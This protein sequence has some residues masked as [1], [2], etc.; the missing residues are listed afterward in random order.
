[1]KKVLYIT[2][3]SNQVGGGMSGLNR[4]L[5]LIKGVPNIDL[6][7][8]QVQMQSKISALYSALTGGNLILSYK[9]EKKSSIRLLPA[10]MISF[11]RKEL[12]VG[13]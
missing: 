2:I 8:C 12:Q 1:M 10:S 4:N 6:H 5:K 11:F 7:I 3:V 9:D 13:I